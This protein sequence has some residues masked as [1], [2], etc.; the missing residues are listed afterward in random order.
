MNRIN[1]KGTFTFTIFSVL[2]LLLALPASEVKAGN[3]PKKKVKHWEAEISISPYYDSNILKYSDKYIDRFVNMQDEGRFHINRYDDLVSKYS[4]RLNYSNKFIKKL[5][6]EFS[7]DFRYSKYSFNPVKNWLRYSV[8]WRQYFLSKSCF[9]ISYSFI[10]HFYVRDFRDED[11]VAVYGYVPSAFKPYEFSKDDISFWVQHYFFKHTNV[12]AYFSYM[13]YFLDPNNTEYDSKDYLYGIRIF[14]KLTKNLYID[15]GYKYIYSNAKGYDQPGE[16][17]QTS[18]DVDATN[19]AHNYLAGIDYK[20][21][22]VFG[23]N[24]RIS[25]DFLYERCFYTTDHFYEL[26]P[27][28][29]GRHDK[30]YDISVTYRLDLSKSVQVSAFYSSLGRKTGTPA[31][32]NAEYISDEKS[33]EQY[34]TGI[35]I[36]YN[37]KF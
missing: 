2:I 8:G 30:N 25:L 14:Q 20:L 28:H 24:N 21:P 22:K 34:Q 7:F 5:N 35:E 10:P 11:W 3:N 18:D 4:V 31:A 17:K 6:S 29:A 13:K 19:Y 16:T 37:I 27:I 26:D 12:R 15:V 1:I 33:Y 9:M 36:S 23:M 32:A